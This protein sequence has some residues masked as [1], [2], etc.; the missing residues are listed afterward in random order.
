MA[1]LMKKRTFYFFLGLLASFFLLMFMPLKENYVFINNENNQVAAYLPLTDL[2]FQIKY[3]HTIHLSDVIESYQVLQDNT[4]MATELEYEDFNIGMPSNAEKGER[5]VE[6]DGKYFIKNMQRKM[7]EFRLFI[8]DVESE[9][10][11]LTNHE[12]FDLKKTLERGTSYTV[13][14]QRLS[15]FQQLKG[16]SLSEQESAA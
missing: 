3:T 16:E 12:K 11:L 9:L 5:F 2:S 15:I 6:K 1:S 8:G 13:K 14:V 10:S 7:P 4:L